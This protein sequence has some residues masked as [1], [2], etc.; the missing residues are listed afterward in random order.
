MSGI[1]TAIVVSAVIGGVAAKKAGDKQ[2]KA[3]DTANAEIG[4][5]F[6]LTREDFAPYREAGL[7]VLPQLTEGLKPGGDFNRDFTIADFYKDPGYDFRLGE[8][9]KALERSAAARGGVT[10]GAAGKELI[11]Y[12]QNFGSN[13]FSNAYSRF[14][15]DRTTRFNRLSALAG[16]G[17]TA[18]NTVATLGNQSVQQQAENTLQKGNAQAAGYVGAANALT[19][20]AQTLGDFYLQQ[21][22][23]KK[24]PQPVKYGGQ[25]PYVGYQG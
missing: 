22:Y 6:D 25:S 8:G 14:N 17:Q 2:A 23:L 9:T 21:Q 20:G 11:R 19:G 13:E 15:N 3:A 7:S 4:R 5:E 12:G 24:I 16:T 10:S 1:A 18:T